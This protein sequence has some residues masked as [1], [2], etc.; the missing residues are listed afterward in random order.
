MFIITAL[1]LIL[2]LV[3]IVVLRSI[4]NEKRLF[5]LVPAGMIAGVV[6]YIFLLNLNN[7]IIHGHA[8]IV[9]ASLQFVLLG[10][11]LY[12]K[13]RKTF[14]KLES[15]RITANIFYFGLIILII[16]LTSLKMTTQ[17]PAADASMQW[18]YAGTFARGNYPIM[19]PWQP[20][21]NPN[22]HLG[23]YF[24]EG[25]L[26]DLSNLK[27]LTVHTLMNIYF[28]IASSLLALFIFWENKYYFKNIWLVLAASILYISFGVIILL[29]PD[30]IQKQPTAGF[31]LEQ[32]ITAVPAKGTGG[33]SLVDLNVL[34]Y[35]PARSLSLG[36]A[37]LALYF[38]YSPFK[39]NK[40][41]IFAFTLL[42]ATSA[43]V[44]ESMFLPLFLATLAVFG[45]SLLYFLPNLQY[46][47]QQRK[48]LI[49][50]ILLTSI[51]VVLQ[52][53]FI[54]ENISNN[55]FSNK[56]SA[57][58]LTIFD[59]SFNEK[60]SVFKNVILNSQSVLFDWFVPSPLLLIIILF[61]YS[62]FK[63]DSRLGL[64]GIFSL[65]AFISYLITEYKYCAACSIRIHSFGMIAAGF[66]LILL[67]FSVF[68]NLSLRKNL[69][70]LGLFIPILFVPSM[71]PD[72]IAQ[73]KKIKEGIRDGVKNIIFSE[74]SQ[75][76]QNRIIKWA[77]KNLPLN[78]RIIII[79]IGIPSP[80]ASLN[81]QYGG[82]YTILGPQYIHVNRQEPGPEFFD[83]ALTLNSSILKRTKTEYLYIES[84]SPAYIQLPQFRK[85]D[86][87]N[88][89]YF[90]LLQSIEYTDTSSGQESF[91]RL[92]KVLPK[93][94]DENIP[95]K[96]IEEG[97]LD[98]LDKLIPNNS[99]V[100]V[101]NYGDPPQMSFWYRMALVLTLK[102]KDLRY[103][104]SQTDYQVIETDIP[105][106]M[107][108]ITEKYNFYVL[109]PQDKP[110][111]PSNLIWSNIYAKGWKRD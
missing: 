62:Y 84:Q 71:V 70:G 103:N 49:V 1:F 36:L 72:L 27:I 39:N 80:G 104:F 96:E 68:K 42:L 60:F 109:G 82:L 61:V 10:L 2:A 108:S 3:G 69:I 78:S 17:F 76:P 30:I 89:N 102:N 18:A 110:P 9:L 75:T 55:P 95:G 63:K 6:I 45:L 12:I 107:G 31:N 81:F 59:R 23:A 44:E 106:I 34:S 53:G 56:E 13:F 73:K 5:T 93:Y 19:T 43:L 65:S 91:F 54:T 90:Q 37:L 77:S 64:I 87:A 32:L 11:F 46:L 100:Y 29:Y 25:A 21:L 85:D 105:H 74:E 99:S 67:L 22:Y 101:A 4:S 28:L 97:T 33:A 47:K 51:S 40:L 98:L 111:I 57:Y 20:D 26:N 94:L 16:F 83:L 86:L 8:G 48:T 58:R 50:I 79:D 14:T 24:L 35:L 7:K 88:K 41:K 38:T 66:G 92:Y 15:M 52:G